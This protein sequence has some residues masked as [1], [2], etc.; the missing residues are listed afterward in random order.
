[1][2]AAIDKT[3]SELKV[4]SYRVIWLS[5]S[6]IVF[7]LVFFQIPGEGQDW[8]G[9]D[10]FFDLL[11]IEGLDVF[12]TSRFE[13]GFVIVSL[14]LT[15]LFPSNLAVFGLIA[16]ISIALKCWAIN[17]FSSSR[18]VFSVVIFVLYQLQEIGHRAGGLVSQ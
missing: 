2:K 3:I 1:M 17:Q 4:R 16:A 7:L 13:P 15:E 9:Y 11:R 14:F 6:L 12:G 5:L 10:Y 18:I 8:Q